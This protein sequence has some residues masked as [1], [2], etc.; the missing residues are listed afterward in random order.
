M[1]QYIILIAVVTFAASLVVGLAP[2]SIMLIAGAAG[3]QAGVPGAL[4]KGYSFGAHKVTGLPARLLGGS[5]I[6]FGIGI[7]AFAVWSLHL[8]SSP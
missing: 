2:F 3:I 6:A 1:N 7:I 8:L 4:G 5:A